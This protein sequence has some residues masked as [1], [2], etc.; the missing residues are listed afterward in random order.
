MSEF[1]THELDDP[2]FIESQKYRELSL[3]LMRAQEHIKFLEDRLQHANEGYER[4]MQL[5]AL[6][7]GKPKK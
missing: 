6:S 7:I 3:K 4:A 5:L 2:K 1:E